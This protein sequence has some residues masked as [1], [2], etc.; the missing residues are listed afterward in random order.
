MESIRVSPLLLTTMVNV[1]LSPTRTAGS[2]EL[3]HFFTVSCGRVMATDAVADTAGIV[4]PYTSSAGPACAESA[5]TVPVG[6]AEAANPTVTVACC[7]GS[8]G[9][10]LAQDK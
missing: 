2:G 4:R 7:P 9:P 8:R 6:D 3:S 5:A 10:R 1:A